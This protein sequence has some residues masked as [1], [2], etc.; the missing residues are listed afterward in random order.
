MLLPESL[1]TQELQDPEYISHDQENI[2]QEPEYFPQ[3]TDNFPQEPEYFPQEPHFFHQE[4]EYLPQEPKFPPRD[5]Y[6]PPHFSSFSFSKLPALPALKSS[7][8]PL[9]TL[10][11]IVYTTKVPLKSQALKTDV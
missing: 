6:L 2:S 8:P 9:T 5:P 10:A 1:L 4:S 3:E 11:P 7:S